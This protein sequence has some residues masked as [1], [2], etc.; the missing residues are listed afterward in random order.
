MVVEHVPYSDDALGEIREQ[1]L[2]LDGVLVWVNPIQEG[3]NRGFLDQLLRDV[4]SQ[5]VWVSAHPDVVLQMGTKEVLSPTRP[6]GRGSDTSL[7]RSADE[8]TRTF[9][10]RLVVKQARGHPPEQPGV[11]WSSRKAWPPPHCLGDEV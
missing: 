4:S 2:T 1:L 8:F 5:G 10:E 11:M 9:P 6:L 7:Y 3:Q